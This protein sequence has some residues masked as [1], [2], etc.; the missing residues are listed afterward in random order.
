MNPAMNKTAL[1]TG[2]AKRLGRE[3]AVALAARGYDL[4]VH[5]NSSL[6]EARECQKLLE[7]HNKKC[8]TIQG[9]LT[10]DA[11]CKKIFD[12]A[13]SSLGTISLL[14]NN[15]SVFNSQGF[16]QTDSAHFD[17]DVGINLKAP[18]FL[19]QDFARQIYDSSSTKSSAAEDS[20][21]H[22]QKG[23]QKDLMV[24]NMLDCN[25]AKLREDYFL[26]HLTKNA[27]HHFTLMAA[28]EL[29]PYIRV[30]AI[31]PGAALPP[32]HK[33][34]AHLQKVSSTAPL[35]IASP[36]DTITQGLEYLLDAKTVTGQVLYV[37]SGMQL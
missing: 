35:G 37:A 21:P 8:I 30:N 5:Y 27:L 22:F 16:M 25:H 6:A 23:F 34:D 2:G 9:E 32:P 20:P 14:I 24:V 1:I 19:T 31:A 15:A 33:D 4:A 28:K 10:D 7:Q 12:E 13:R 36:P 26:Y 17:K 11:A 3:M 18:F 29:A